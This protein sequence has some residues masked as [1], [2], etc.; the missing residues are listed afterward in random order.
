[1]KRA[2]LILML[3]AL[4]AFGQFSPVGNAG[5]SSG[6]VVGENGGTVTSVAATVPSILSVSGSPITEAGTLA[7]SHTT[8]SANMIWASRIAGR[9][10]TPTFRALVAADLPASYTAPLAT[11]LA[12]PR[13]IKGTAFDGTAAI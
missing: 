4:P 13:A 12:T 7:F 3:A 1:M 10:A 5:G 9:A 6:P 11:A 8:Q 2:L